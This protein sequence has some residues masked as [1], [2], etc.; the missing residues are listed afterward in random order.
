MDLNFKDKIER[1]FTN[2]K[3]SKVNDTNY[4][5]HMDCKFTRKKVCYCKSNGRH[6]Q[7]VIFA[8][9]ILLFV[10]TRSK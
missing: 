7:K 2:F 6:S 10:G 1:N 3:T 5:F 9:F 8:I 4:L